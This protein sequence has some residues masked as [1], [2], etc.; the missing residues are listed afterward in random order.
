MKR[1]PSIWRGRSARA[2]AG[3]IVMSGSFAGGFGFKATAQV[4]API[5]ASAGG[6]SAV[7]SALSLGRARSS[8]MASGFGA[9]EKK[10]AM[11]FWPGYEAIVYHC[12]VQSACPGCCPIA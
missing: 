1:Q 4:G 3:C 9:A 6:V 7:A 5:A 8:D 11:P 2:K 10:L 12:T